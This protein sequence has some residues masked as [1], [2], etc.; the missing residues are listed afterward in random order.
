MFKIKHNKIKR[1]K[2]ITNGL[3]NSINK[4]D[5]ICMQLKREP[6][7]IELQTHYKNYKQKLTKLI[8]QTKANYYRAKINKNKEN[9]Q[10]LWK[11]VKE[12]GKQNHSNPIS[13]IKREN[14]EVTTDLQELTN[15]F[16]KTFSEMGKKLAQ[17]IHKNK[18]Y[19]PPQE[20]SINTMFL[21]PTNKFEISNI[22]MTLKNKKSPGID[23]IKSETLKY[24]TTQIE[25]PLTFII[26]KIF[27]TGEV[28]VAFKTSVIKPIYKNGD[29]LDSNNYRPI[30]LITNITKIFEKILKTRINDYIKRYKI[31]SSRQYGFQEGKSTEDAIAC[32][33]E[34]LYSNLDNSKPS[35][36]VFLDLAKAF[37]TVSHELLL[38]SLNNIGIRGNTLNLIKNYLCGRKQCVQVNSVKSKF[39]GI[40]YGVPQGT[41]LGPLLFIIYLNNLFL[42]KTEAHIVSFADDTVLLYHSNNWDNLKEIVEQDLKCIKDWFD[43][44]LLTINFQKTFFLPFTSYKSSLPKYESINLKIN[45]AEIIEIKSKASIKYLGIYI[46]SFLKWDVHTQYIIKKLRS[47]LYLIKNLKEILKLEELYVL[48]QTLIETHLRYGIIA[49]GGVQKSYL[50]DLEIIQ[51]KILKIIYGKEITYSSD[52]LYKETKAFDIRQLYFYCNCIRQFKQKNQHPTISHNCNTRNKENKYQTNIARKTIGQRCFSYLAPRIYNVL[53]LEIRKIF[54]FNI[55]KKRCKDYIHKMP[56]K[57]VHDQIDLKN[58]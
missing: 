49:W 10:Y 33:T 20:N 30:S 4:R 54:S 25:Q 26:N 43:N 42:I 50:N 27:E 3:V 48:Y 15:I 40:E 12:I 1:T 46:D 22:I 47:L 2:W 39:E 13:K 28:P 55:F 18:L 41:V 57:F 37:D 44:R 32:I 16:V 34:K 9:P 36:A 38:D 35:L 45:D 5:K 23:G 58:S 51:K 21:V 19:T 6:H 11:T 24:I 31:L 53:P 17:K 14:G 7:N 29:K 52:L 56:R 8:K